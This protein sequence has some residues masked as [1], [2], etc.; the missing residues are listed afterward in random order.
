MEARVELIEQPFPAGEEQVLDGLDCPIPI[1]ADESVQ[2]RADLQNV[3]GRS[4]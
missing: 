1:A 3:V 4:R 2:D